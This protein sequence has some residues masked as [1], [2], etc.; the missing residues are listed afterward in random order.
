MFEFSD[1]HC[2]VDFHYRTDVVMH[3]V[4]QDVKIAWVGEILWTAEGNKYIVF[5]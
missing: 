3:Y 2:L 4:L 5:Y 1:M